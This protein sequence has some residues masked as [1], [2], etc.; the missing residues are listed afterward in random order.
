MYSSSAGGLQKLSAKGVSRYAQK[1]FTHEVYQKVL[2]TC[3]SINLLNTKIGSR[4][5]QIQIIQI[6]KV[7]LSCFDDK[8]FLMENGVSIDEAQLPQNAPLP[9]QWHVR[10]SDDGQ[11]T[12][13][14]ELMEAWS[15]PDPGFNQRE[16]SDSGL[17]NNII[18]DENNEE[19]SPQRN[20][21]IDDEA[22]EAQDE[23]EPAEE[24][25]EESVLNVCIIIETLTEDDANAIEDL[26]YL[27]DFDRDE[28][29]VNRRRRVKRRRMEI[30]SD[31]E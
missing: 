22:A 6:N 19:Q 7:Y 18:S 24:D 16:Y 5:H 25:D 14:Q 28:D 9:S 4:K 10:L 23:A 21:F 29:F 15:P 2:Q 30:V 12:L 17:D 3:R 27:I 8:R 11:K 31:S 13:T 1:D 26:E 20:P